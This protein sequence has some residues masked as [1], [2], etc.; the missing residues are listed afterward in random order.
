MC[1]LVLVHLTY[2]IAYKLLFDRKT[3]LTVVI[4][5]SIENVIN[6]NKPKVV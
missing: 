1:Y 5:P 6:K 2:L 3:S 4:D